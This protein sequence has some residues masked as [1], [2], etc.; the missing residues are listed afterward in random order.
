VSGANPQG[1]GTI[2]R[3]YELLFVVQPTLEEEQLNAFVEQ[4]KDTITSNEGVVTEATIMGRRQLAYPIGRYRDGYY[5]LVAAEMAN[6]TIEAVKRVLRLSEDVLRDMMLRVEPAVV[7]EE[8]AESTEQDE[9]NGARSGEQRSRRHRQKVCYFCVED[10]D[11]IDYKD[12][13]LLRRFVNQRGR[14]LPRRRT[15]ACAKHQRML[16]NA[17]KRARYMALLPCAPSHVREND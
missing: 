8:A 1:G 6:T 14:I 15:N 17:I 13:A 7:V 3:S 16:T 11:E 2:L 5:V 12:V 9:E 10:I 4:I